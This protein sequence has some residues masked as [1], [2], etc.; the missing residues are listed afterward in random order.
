MEDLK[1]LDPQKSYEWKKETEF[2]LSGEEFALM[3][4]NVNSFLQSALSPATMLK[5]VDVSIILQKKLADAVQNGEA[6]EKETNQ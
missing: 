6:V 4:N 5:L 1:Q 2:K 3:Y